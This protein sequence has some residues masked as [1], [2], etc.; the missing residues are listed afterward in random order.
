MI[1]VENDTIT[2][3]LR[4]FDRDDEDGDV[5]ETLAT[6][7]TDEKYKHLL[8]HPV[9]EAFL[10]IK[11]DSI[12]GW[13]FLNWFIYLIFLIVLTSMVYLARYLDIES[14]DNWHKA[15]W[16]I[17]A[18]LVIRELAQILTSKNICTDYF[19]KLE[20]WIDWF[21]ILTTIFY[22]ILLYNDENNFQDKNNK[23]SQIE[24]AIENGSKN[25]WTINYGALALLSGKYYGLFTEVPNFCWGYVGVPLGV[26]WESG[27]VCWRSAG[28]SALGPLGVH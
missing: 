12:W 21:V 19:W 14:N 4:P 5:L 6:Q 16:V 23:S 3:D 17:L 13:Y 27:G 1:K 18:I 22:L 2:F 15:L 28:W 10:L 8:K 7:F 20:N 25:Q 24:I 11:W 9:V 26:R